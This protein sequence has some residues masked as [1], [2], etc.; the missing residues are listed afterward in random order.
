MV[1]LYVWELNCHFSV[2]T[3]MDETG[4]IET[5]LGAETK[6]PHGALQC[7]HHRT[8]LLLLHLVI[9]GILCLS[10]LPS[11]T[12]IGRRR[13]APQREGI[14]PVPLLRPA[15]FA[16]KGEEEGLS[17][18]SSAQEEGRKRIAIL[19]PFPPSP[20]EGRGKSHI[21][22]HLRLRLHPRYS[23]ILLLLFHSTFPFPPRQIYSRDTRRRKVRGTSSRTV[24][25]KKTQ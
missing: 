22:C 1:Y 7:P 13:K 11:Q 2:A 17:R 9:P 19:L 15:A 12:N 21:F 5:D 18:H 14:I 20:D 24:S 4:Q 25:Q 3:W 10:L 23:L 6:K 16:Q 8:F